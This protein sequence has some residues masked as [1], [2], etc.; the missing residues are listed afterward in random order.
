MGRI[1]S[2]PPLTY[3]EF[4]KR[5]NRLKRRKELKHTEGGLT[6]ATYD[7]D[8]EEGRLSLEDTNLNKEEITK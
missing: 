8:N 2:P 7:P 6:L 5:I 1:P 3:E 4:T